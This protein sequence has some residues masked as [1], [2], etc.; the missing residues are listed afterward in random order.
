M[1][2]RSVLLN[3]TKQLEKIENEYLRCVGELERIELEI[4]EVLK[5]NPDI[6]NGDVQQDGPDIEESLDLMQASTEKATYCPISLHEILSGQGHILRINGEE[7]SKYRIRLEKRLTALMNL[8][9]SVQRELDLKNIDVVKVRNS[10]KDIEI[11]RLRK[12]LEL[13]SLS[14]EQAKTYTESAQLPSGLLPPQHDQAMLTVLN[15]TTH[16]STSTSSR[17]MPNAAPS[18]ITV[19]DAAGMLVRDLQ[20]VRGDS[21]GLPGSMMGDVNEIGQLPLHASVAEPFGPHNESLSSPVTRDSHAF[22]DVS[23]SLTSVTS[24]KHG[25]VNNAI[26]SARHNAVFRTESKERSSCPPSVND[27]SSTY[28][29]A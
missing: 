8:D 19:E 26:H 21:S 28:D 25:H 18:K 23:S 14:Q 7:P 27:G 4:S 6:T 3:T 16:H 17:G 29:N 10:L 11:N 12:E 1:V 9:A 22:T 20:P 24:V 15:H 2:T 13:S 5:W